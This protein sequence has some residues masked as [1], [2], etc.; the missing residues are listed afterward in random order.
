MARGGGGKQLFSVPRP[1]QGLCAP[2]ALRGKTVVLTGIFPELGGG[3]GLELGARARALVECFGGRVTS[4]V[5]GRTDA[6]LVGK[7]PG[8]SKVTKARN[9]S[10]CALVNLQQL[11]GELTGGRG[12]AGQ[13]LARGR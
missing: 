2:G 8:M 11:C 3:A 9:Q 5:S 10:G 12:A 4:A 7:D 13:G 6:L 1:G